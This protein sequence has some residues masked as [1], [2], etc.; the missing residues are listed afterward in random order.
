M[1]D[2]EFIQ[3]ESVAPYFTEIGADD[4][5]IPVWTFQ[6]FGVVGIACL[7]SLGVSVFIALLKRA[8]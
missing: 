5:Q 4:F 3:D 7:I 2:E 6:G 8:L 1:I